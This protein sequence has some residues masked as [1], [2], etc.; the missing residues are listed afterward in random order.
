MVWRSKDILQ[1]PEWSLVR[2]LY[3]AMGIQRC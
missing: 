3:K 1:P 2:G